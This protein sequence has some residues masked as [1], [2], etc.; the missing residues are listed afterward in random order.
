[1]GLRNWILHNKLINGGHPSRSKDVNIKETLK[2]H[3][4][5]IWI[6]FLLIL[7]TVSFKAISEERQIQEVMQECYDEANMVAGIQAARIQ[8]GDSMKDF[9]QHIKQNYKPGE[10]LGN[11]TTPEL[12]ARKDKFYEQ[13]IEYAIIVYE[14]V[15]V[16]VEPERLYQDVLNLCVVG[17]T[18]KKMK[19]KK[20]QKYSL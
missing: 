13:T 4:P 7:V 18:F 3:G 1:M 15:P 11:H 10:P 8:S 2:R 5:T 6:A 9:V 20:V 17:K 19:D 16:E 12:I 14:T